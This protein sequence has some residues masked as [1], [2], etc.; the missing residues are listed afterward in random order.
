[1]LREVR[2]PPGFE[3]SDLP[4]LYTTANGYA[5]QYVRA[6]L[7]SLPDD[8]QRVVYKIK[9][10]QVG[11]L[12][13]WAARLYAETE[14]LLS[15]QHVSASQVFEPIYS[16]LVSVNGD[17]VV[18]ALEY[19]MRVMFA[20]TTRAIQTLETLRLRAGADVPPDASPDDAKADH[21]A[22]ARYFNAALALVQQRQ[23]RCPSGETVL[24]SRKCL[25]VFAPS[26]FE[27]VIETILKH[28][29]ALGDVSTA[30]ES[31]VCIWVVWLESA[32]RLLN[33]GAAPTPNTESIRAALL[34]L[35][36]PQ[37][38]AELLTSLD[39]F[40]QRQHTSLLQHQGFDL[41]RHE[42]VS[43]IRRHIG[44]LIATHYYWDSL[45]MHTYALE[46]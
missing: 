24:Y 6:E 42:T 43:R 19:F 12:F 7:D 9:H 17:T 18:S 35:P 10:A 2:A 23:E 45:L 13:I 30:C 21:G 22:V 15:S 14:A 11:R 25:E 44:D 4:A 20:S 33:L 28:G 32:Q 3:V 29:S 41:D 37:A 31:S 26:V 36:M 8:G 1:V 40:I 34:A 5:R 16:A 46:K 27:N 39:V 38:L